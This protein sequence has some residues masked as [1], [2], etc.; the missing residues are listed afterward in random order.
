MVVFSICD[1]VRYS[2]PFGAFLLVLSFA[3]LLGYEAVGSEQR[4]PH[5]GGSSPR[6]YGW[7]RPD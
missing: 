2:Y 3:F 7:A 1:S 4:P 5:A 6:W